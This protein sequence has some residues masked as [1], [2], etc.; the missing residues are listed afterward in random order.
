MWAR[1][2]TQLVKSGELAV[3]RWC[4]GIAWKGDNR[5]MLVQCMAE[6]EINVVR[7]TGGT[8]NSL[9]KVGAIKTKGGPAG[10]RT[11]EP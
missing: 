8:G 11:A 3:G 7:F 2:G 6:E 9:S 1:N 5:T 10:I 4:Q